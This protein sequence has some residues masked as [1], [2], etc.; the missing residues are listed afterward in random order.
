VIPLSKLKERFDD[1]VEILLAVGYTQMNDL[2][3][4]IYR[5]LYIRQYLRGHWHL[6]HPTDLQKKERMERNEIQVE[7]I[8][9]GIPLRQLKSP[10][11]YQL[12]C[13]TT[14]K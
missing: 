7:A 8:Q 11:E 13:Y 9:Y 1:G 4:R 12:R 14:N 3:E 6:E 5:M 10:D 2:R